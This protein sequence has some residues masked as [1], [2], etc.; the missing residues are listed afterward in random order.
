MVQTKLGE[1]VRT[2][3]PGCSASTSE[4]VLSPRNGL[5]DW[6]DVV[7]VAA[8]CSLGGDAMFLELWDR[9]EREWEGKREREEGGRES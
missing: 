9:R 2:S 8:F 1:L 4:N 6:E 7:G 3:S 5:E